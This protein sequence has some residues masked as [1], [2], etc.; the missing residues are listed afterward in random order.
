MQYAIIWDMVG[1]LVDSYPAIVPAALESLSAQGIDFDREKLYQEVIRTSV[2]DVLEKIAAE[3]KKRGS[4]GLLMKE[5]KDI[6]GVPVVKG[7]RRYLTGDEEG[8]PE[9][10]EIQE[11]EE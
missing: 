3:H 4:Y 10:V 8:F 9:L 2:G 5:L 11:E 1:T 6:F 7:T